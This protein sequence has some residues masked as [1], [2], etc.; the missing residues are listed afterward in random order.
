MFRSEVEAGDSSRY[1]VIDEMGV[2]LAMTRR[3]GRAPRGERVTERVP[4]NRGENVTVIGAGRLK[5][6][7][8]S[9]SF[10]GSL[11]SELLEQFA[12]EVLIPTLTRGDIVFLD[13][14]PAH[15]DSDIEDILAEYG[16]TV[17]WFPAYSP[18][19]NP[20]E[21]FWSKIKEYVRSK[22][23][24][25]REALETALFEEFQTVTPSDWR[26]WFQHCGYRLVPS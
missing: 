14:L 13:N 11:T 7:D 1:V 24:R 12:E 9:M 2:N 25:T 6:V 22:K 8:A 19:L 21:L 10:S 5:G 17:V 26:G 20:I 15:R 4:S 23:P 3:Y 16:V 18:D